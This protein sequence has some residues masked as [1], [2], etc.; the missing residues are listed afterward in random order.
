MGD[1]GDHGP[2][3]GPPSNIQYITAPPPLGS[4][5]A[6]APVLCLSPLPPPPPAGSDARDTIWTREYGRD[7]ENKSKSRHRFLPPHTT[8]SFGRSRVAVGTDGSRILSDGSPPDSLTA[9]GEPARIARA[10]AIDGLPK[11]AG[12]RRDRRL[13][14]PNERFSAP[15]R[16]YCDLAFQGTVLG[17]GWRPPVLV[18][19]A[20][21]CAS[22]STSSD[23]TCR[24]K[25]GAQ[26]LQLYC[27]SRAE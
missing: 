20:L 6:S 14:V 17:C 27:S 16:P 4:G 21:G 10:T 11:G 15:P 18:P 25:Q 26:R 24:C 8:S 9:D 23:H 3:P 1:L 5:S 7:E 2:G 19:I 12:P 13:S 22:W